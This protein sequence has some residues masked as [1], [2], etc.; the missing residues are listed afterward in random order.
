M[1]KKQGVPAP[2]EK[3][4]AAAYYKLNL[5]AVEDLVTANEENSPVI[6]KEELR[7]YQSGPKIKLED[8]V[9]AALIKIWFAGAV[10]F[11]FLWGLAIA[12]VVIEV[13]GLALGI[14]VFGTIVQLFSKDDDGSAGALHSVQSMPA[15][16]LCDDGQRYHYV[17]GKAHA[18][19]YVG[20]QR[21]NTVTI[22]DNDINP[23]ARSASVMGYVFRW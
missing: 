17:K 21:K 15:T 12:I 14:D 16:I 23:G 3:K 5:R 2:E 7:K 8:W 22:H 13:V 20:E 9:K 10:C 11:F 1:A 6:S 19:V 4:A 18:S